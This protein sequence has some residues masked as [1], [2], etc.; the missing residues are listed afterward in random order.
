MN[1]RE[2]SDLYKREIVIY[3]ENKIASKLSEDAI[4]LEFILREWG[5]D[6]KIKILPHALF[7]DGIEFWLYRDRDKFGEASIHC[8][9]CNHKM[10]R[11]I[12]TKEDILTAANYLYNRLAEHKELCDMWQAQKAAPESRG[13]NG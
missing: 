10:S 4:A 3:E 2:R 11:Y 5:I 12:Y 8:Q 9:I 13:R 7:V 1:L 6:S